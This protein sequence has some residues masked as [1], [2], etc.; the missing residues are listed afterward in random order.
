MSVKVQDRRVKQGHQQLEKKTIEQ[1]GRKQLP[2]YDP[3]GAE[4]E[5]H[6]KGV[7]EL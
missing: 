4:Q 5:Q 7:E 1:Q 3:E 2:V 6:R